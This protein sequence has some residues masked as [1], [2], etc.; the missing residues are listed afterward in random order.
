MIRNSFT[1][2]LHPLSAYAGFVSVNAPAASVSLRSPDAAYHTCLNACSGPVLFT[3][4]PGIHHCLSGCEPDGLIAIAIASTSVV[5]LMYSL[6][7]FNG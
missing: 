2:V 5:P 4:W 6:D 1:G 3:R 7:V